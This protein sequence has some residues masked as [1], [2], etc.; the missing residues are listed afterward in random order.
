MFKLYN[1]FL[2]GNPD[3][4]AKF[5]KVG[6]D[7]EL[8][9]VENLKSQPLD[10]I[11]RHKEV[12]Y[13]RNSYG[14]R[15]VEPHKLQ[16]PFILFT[17]CSITEGI[18]LSLEDTYPYI[19]SNKLGYDYYNLGL[20]GFG[21][22]MLSLNL[23]SWFKN[24]N[25]IPDAVVIQWPQ[26]HRKFELINNTAVPVGPWHDKSDNIISKKSWED[27]NKI[28]TTDYMEHYFNILKNTTTSYLQSMNIKVIE[29]P[30]EDVP[31]T[32]DRGRDLTHPGIESHK[33]L[34]DKVLNSLGK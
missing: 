28:I 32:S 7:S 11:Y 4:D 1:N 20:N 23:S 10:W 17:G 21:I 26:I 29:I 19:V 33:F 25:L 2:Y 3:V 30:F 5:S 18:A 12:S 34:A 15:S 14:H 31:L 16:S 27:Y 22:D 13:K 6:S 9:Y 24:I 8:K